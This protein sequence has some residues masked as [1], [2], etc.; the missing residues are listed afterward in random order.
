MPSNKNERKSESEH[1]SSRS[2]EGPSEHES[3]SEHRGSGR[4]HESRSGGREHESRGGSGNKGEEQSLK[5]REYRDE[6]GNIHHH[7]KTY[8]DQ[9]DKK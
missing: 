1:R 9:H 8:M 3:R 4:E 5:E 2:E 7:T 6:Q